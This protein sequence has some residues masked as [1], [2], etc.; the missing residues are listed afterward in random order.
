MLQTGNEQERAGLLAQAQR[1]VAEEAVA[2]YL[3][4]PLWITV[5][6]SKLQGLWQDMPVFVNDLSALRWQ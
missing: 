4:Q 1:L 3:Y 5:A 2:V 6:N